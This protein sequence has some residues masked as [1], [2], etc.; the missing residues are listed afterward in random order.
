MDNEPSTSLEADKN[1]EHALISKK[2]SNTR[3]EEQPAVFLHVTVTRKEIQ[4]YLFTKFQ[5]ITS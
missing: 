2:L 3:E 5:V 1:A 4:N